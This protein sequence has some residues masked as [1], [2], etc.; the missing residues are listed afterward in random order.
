M[1]QERDVTVMFCDIVGFTTLCE[2]LEPAVIGELLNSFFGPMADVIF[3]HEGTLDK[4]A[5]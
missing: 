3:D 5:P 2:Q 4:F 1:T